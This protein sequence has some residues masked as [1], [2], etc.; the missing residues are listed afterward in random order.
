MWPFAALASAMVLALVTASIG[1]ALDQPAPGSQ[2]QRPDQEPLVF[3]IS[4]DEELDRQIS[5]EVRFIDTEP[6]VWRNGLKGRWRPLRGRSQT[7]PWIV[8]EGS[9][10]LVLDSIM[11]LPSSRM[12]IAPKPTT[13]AGHHLIIKAESPVA[14]RSRP[15]TTLKLCGH[16]NPQTIHMSVEV[17][18]GEKKPLRQGSGAPADQAGPLINDSFDLP[19][20][21]SL[22]LSLDR[23]NPSAKAGGDH[24]ERLIV[25]TPRRI[26]L[27]SEENALKGRRLTP[28]S[29]H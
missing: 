16:V 12:T 6:E 18:Q 3:S 24:S 9:F 5:F 4:F 17:S 2:A 27:G 14:G 19:D 20:G 26:L 25:I 28:P 7:G 15:A 22:L 8:D 23:A 1:F 29:N 13:F 10:R 11:A 21:S